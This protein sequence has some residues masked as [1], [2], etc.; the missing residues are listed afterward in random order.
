MHLVVEAVAS[1]LFDGV[2]MISAA[3]GKIEVGTIDS[4]Q[5]Q[6][7]VGLGERDFLVE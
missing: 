1:C 4:Y 7:F 5:M 3:G 6:A 2:S